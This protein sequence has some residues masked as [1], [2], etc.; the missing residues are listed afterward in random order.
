M[1]DSRALNTDLHSSVNAI[2]LLCGMCAPGS[3]HCGSEQWL[4]GAGPGTAAADPLLLRQP[5]QRQARLAGRAAYSP[6]G[7]GQLVD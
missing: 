1:L 3:R 7:G 6:K 4:G 5:K 2:R